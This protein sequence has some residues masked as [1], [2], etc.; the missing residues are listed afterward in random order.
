MKRN[1]DV[2]SSIQDI[3]GIWKLLKW[4]FNYLTETHPDS[5]IWTKSGLVVLLDGWQN[6]PNNLPD[7]SEIFGSDCT[8]TIVTIRNALLLMSPTIF[9]SFAI[10]SRASSLCLWIMFSLLAKLVVLI[11]AHFQLQ[12]NFK[13]VTCFYFRT[14]FQNLFRHFKLIFPDSSNCT[15]STVIPPKL[16]IFLL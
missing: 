1:L 8:V 11:F 2:N 4:C 6:P 12:Q 13:V 5:G 15:I 14:S 7:S 3:T 10:F 16:Q 9:F